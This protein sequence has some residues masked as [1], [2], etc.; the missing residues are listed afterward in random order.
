MTTFAAQ[1]SSPEKR[2]FHLLGD[3]SI[4][5]HSVIWLNTSISS[6]QTVH[7]QKLHSLFNYLQIFK[8]LDECKEYIS[9]ISSQH[10]VILIISGHS[11]ERVISDIHDFQQVFSI[12][13]HCEEE[14]LHNQWS[15]EYQKVILTILYYSIADRIFI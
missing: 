15:K 1:L 12:Y 4:G 9:L 7:T 10:R 11:D 3:N 13:I 5:T 2:R 14:Q 8:N 6:Q